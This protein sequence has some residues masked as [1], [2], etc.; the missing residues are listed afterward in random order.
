MV[1]LLILSFKPPLVFSVEWKHHIGKRVN[2]FDVTGNTR[3]LNCRDCRSFG[4]IL[5]WNKSCNDQ[6]FTDCVLLLYFSWIAK[7]LV[8]PSKLVLLTGVSLLGICV[9]IGIIIL[10][11]HLKEK[12]SFNI[13]Q[14]E[15]RNSPRNQSKHELKDLSFSCFLLEDRFV[16][17]SA[18]LSSF[19]A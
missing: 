3:Q 14:R 16:H 15:S 12:V 18:S 11:L 7:L 6:R 8:T 9:F 5:S 17:V 13:L 10:L 19:K 1:K 2:S 4:R